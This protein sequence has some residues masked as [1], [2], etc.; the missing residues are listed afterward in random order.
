MSELVQACRMKSNHG[1]N[2]PEWP[3]AS[4]CGILAT[5]TN[6]CRPFLVWV[7]EAAI[8]AESQ[9]RIT[10]FEN[11][12]AGAAHLPTMRELSNTCPTPDTA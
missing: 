1:W 5:D 8:A 3:H 2:P 9:Q 12:S 7:R 11:D 10:Y 6:S 4:R